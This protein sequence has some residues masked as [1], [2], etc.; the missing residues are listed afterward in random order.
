MSAHVLLL[1]SIYVWHTN[2]RCNQGFGVIFNR[3][4]P[5]LINPALCML[6]SLL[7]LL[8]LRLQ[9]LAQFR[10]SA[11]ANRGSALFVRVPP[12]EERVV[13]YFGIKPE[14]MP[15]AVLGALSKLIV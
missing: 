14:D 4:T 3:V 12:T 5:L 10:A 11:L 2:F 6:S 9:A 1:L 7:L 8:L 15:T 13:S